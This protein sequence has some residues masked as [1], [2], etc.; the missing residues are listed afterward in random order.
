MKVGTTSATRFS[1]NP[2]IAGLLCR[3]SSPARART[4]EALTRSG[5]LRRNQIDVGEIVVR[6]CIHLVTLHLLAQRVE[7][8]RVRYGDPGRLLLH[9]DLRLL[10]ELRAVRL[11]RRLG[12]LDDQLFE[13][14]VA[15]AGDVAAA[16]HRLAAKEWNEE[17]VGIAV[18]A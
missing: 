18:V 15:P 8:D 16:F 6:C 14:L 2:I 1:R 9:D 13:W 3:Q 7:T 17:V 5:L 10:V 11:L 12:G 4:G